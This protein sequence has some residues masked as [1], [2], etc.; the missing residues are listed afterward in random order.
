MTVAFRNNTTH[1]TTEIPDSLLNMNGKSSKR[2]VLHT[3]EL[4]KGRYSIGDVG[5]TT[6]NALFT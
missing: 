5:K 2:S 4:L 3:L 1:D 6:H